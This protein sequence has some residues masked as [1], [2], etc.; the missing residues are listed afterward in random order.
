MEPYLNEE[1]QRLVEERDAEVE[2]EFERME[3]QR[4]EQEERAREAIDELVDSLQDQ[5]I[6]VKAI[7]DLEEQL[8]EEIEEEEPEDETKELPDDP[9]AAL[10]AMDISEEY[11]SLRPYYTKIYQSGKTHYAGY[12]SGA[13]DVWI[14]CSGSGSGVFGEGACEGKIY[15][16]RW[17]AF[18][19][20]R[21]GY[22]DFH[23]YQPYK[24]Q[25]IVKS[26][27]GFFTSKEAKAKIHVQVRALQNGYW[28]PMSQWQVES[29]GGDNIN[30][31]DRLDDT[32]YRYYKAQL[33][34]NDQAYALV[35][36][37]FYVYARG[38]GSYAKNDFS[39]GSSN[40]L[41]APWVTV[42]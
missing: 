26:D 11:W 42:Y 31:D 24:G 30:Y 12:H 2:A 15:V 34:V 19:P 29:V 4:E 7:W 36:Q 39:T 27:D 5:D 22:F 25:M 8:E 16:D 18:T 14:S 9:G 21:S 37:E 33:G 6:D 32:D 10:E 13:V 1:L 38:S 17:Y 35:T 23:V 40:Y 3:T 20:N 41:G 28:K